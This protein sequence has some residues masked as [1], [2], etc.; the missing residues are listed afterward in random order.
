MTLGG[1]RGEPPGSSLTGRTLSSNLAWG[2]LPISLLAL[3]ASTT[4]T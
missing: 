2:R 3:L 1:A 4:E